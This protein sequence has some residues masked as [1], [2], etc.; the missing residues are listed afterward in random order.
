M[1]TPNSKMRF[2]RFLEVQAD[3][4]TLWPPP[5]TIFGVKKV[6]E[7]PKS[8]KSHFWVR[9]RHRVKKSLWFRKNYLEVWKRPGK[10]RKID[11]SN[12]DFSIF[13][14]FRWFSGFSGFTVNIRQKTTDNEGAKMSKK[15]ILAKSG[16]KHPQTTLE[17]HLD[18]F[19]DD[20]DRL[21]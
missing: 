15:I 3:F 1:T 10:G 13:P 21:G 19:R 20:W 5:L 12:L 11:F 6:P 16:L 7:P 17:S 18:G 14:N 4:L 8:K 2:F 9:S